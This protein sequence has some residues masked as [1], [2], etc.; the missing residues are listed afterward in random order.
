[1]AHL[2]VARARRICGANAYAIRCA[3]AGSGALISV[4][5]T[6]GWATT[7]ILWSLHGLYR[8]GIPG[9]AFPWHVLGGTVKRTHLRR[10]RKLVNHGARQHQGS[11]RRSIGPQNVTLPGRLDLVHNDSLR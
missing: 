1:M 4:S 10:P 9:G 3:M 7:G 2:S 5:G 8:D 11:P 6:R